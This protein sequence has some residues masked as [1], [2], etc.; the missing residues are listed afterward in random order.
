MNTRLTLPLFII[1]SLSL[2]SVH[3]EAR[4]TPDKPDACTDI[5]NTLEQPRNVEHPISQDLYF[6]G[7]QCL[8][9]NNQP[10]QA[11]T[12]LENYFTF[13]NKGDPYFKQ[14]TEL[15]F[16]L[17][18]QYQSNAAPAIK[19]STSDANLIHKIKSLSSMDMIKLSPGCF[20]MGSPGSEI[21]RAEEEKAHPVCITRP[22]LLGQYEVTQGQWEAIMGEN[23]A[24]F[25][26]CGN[27]CPI[28]NVSWEQI[29]SFITR[30]N[31]KSGLKFRLPTEAEWEYAARAGTDT[32][33][34]FGNQLSTSQANYDGDH[35]YT[36]KHSGRDRKQPIAVGSLKANAWGLYDMHGN[37]MEAIQDWHHIDYY[38][39]SPKNNPQGPKTGSF[40][41]RRGGSWRYGA[42]FCRS[43][44][45][46]RVRPEASSMLMGFRLA[47]DMD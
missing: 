8:Y 45:R 10:E 32:P 39:H 2:P 3:A 26:E 40:R 15:Y 43:A 4:L 1:T 6:L 13:A 37:V 44:F 12:Q 47:L 46:G 17:E 27:Q 30:L 9:Q 23:P 36:G 7:S 18:K 25:K 31:K 35:P 34:A 14:A 24:H 33:F 19:L 38:S 28:E 5:L 11:S 22:F 20:S 42:R 21:E 16:A 41:A 29:Q